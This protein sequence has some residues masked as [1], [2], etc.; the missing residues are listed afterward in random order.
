MDKKKIAELADDIQRLVRDTNI[1]PDN[2]E[3]ERN[4][5]LIVTAAEDIKEEAT[6]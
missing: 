3:A 4:L 5:D 6:G 1:D 2:Y